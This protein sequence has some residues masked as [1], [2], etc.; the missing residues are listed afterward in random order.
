MLLHEL[1]QFLV[2]LP[3][4][5]VTTS[6]VIPTIYS[7]KFIFLGADFLAPQSKSVFIS[8]WQCSIFFDCFCAG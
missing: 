2:V 8:A 4:L 5:L 6:P 7:I 3:C 1:K